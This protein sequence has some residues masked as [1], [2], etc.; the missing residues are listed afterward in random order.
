MMLRYRPA[1]VVMGV[2]VAAA[3]AFA[4]CGSG[5]S[6]K[7]TA[8]Q[9]S[10]SSTSTAA[11]GG[12]GASESSGTVPTAAPTSAQASSGT[13]PADACTL[14]TDQEASQIAGGT[15]KGNTAS[16]VEG[17]FAPGAT[18]G[19][20]H[21][22]GDQ[23]TGDHPV[24]VTVTSFSDTGAAQKFMQSRS[25]L[26]K[27][28]PGYESVANLSDEAFAYNLPSASQVLIRR[29]SL[30]LELDAGSK[31]FPAPPLSALEAAARTAN[32]RL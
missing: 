6:S 19:A 1:P 4:A 25:T 5:G 15:V 28:L 10:S 21:Y 8:T 9:P 24:S 17:E 14:L 3:L 13:L 32:G 20:C 7:S 22:Y 23:G 26:G 2:A 29:G 18:T 16:P 27:R 11:S 31:D 30:V 12:T